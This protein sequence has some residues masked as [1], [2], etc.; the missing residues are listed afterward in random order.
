MKWEISPYVVSICVKSASSVIESLFS[1]VLVGSHFV[2]KA[3]QPPE[4]HFYGKCQNLFWP[5][6]AKLTVRNV[7]KRS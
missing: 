2:C 5:S 7:Y 4:L 3:E 1:S 6:R